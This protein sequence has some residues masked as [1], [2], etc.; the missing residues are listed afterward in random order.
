LENGDGQNGQRQKTKESN[1][2]QQSTATGRQKKNLEKG[3]TVRGRE[4]GDGEERR[5]TRGEREAN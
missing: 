3:L 5:P 1:G 4:M 2:S